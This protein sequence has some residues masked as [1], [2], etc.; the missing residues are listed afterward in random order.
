MG[1]DTRVRLDDDELYRILGSVK[2]LVIVYLT[3]S[4]FTLESS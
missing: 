3:D 4:L 2:S 1:W